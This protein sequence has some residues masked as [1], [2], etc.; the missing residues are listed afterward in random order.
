MPS[1][2]SFVSLGISALL[3]LSVLTMTTQSSYAEPNANRTYYCFDY[4]Y[5]D[6]NTGQ[7]I[8]GSSACADTTKSCESLK[9]RELTGP[10]VV[11]AGECY[12]YKDVNPNNP[13]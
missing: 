5:I 2:L 12:K 9:A 10:V 4:D 13:K 8:T 3:M 7:I 6:R 1:K 11:S